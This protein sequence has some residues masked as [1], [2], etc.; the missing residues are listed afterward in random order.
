MLK[1][2][3]DA[4][5]ISVICPVYNARPDLL[6]AS[7][8]S[9]LAVASMHLHEL[10]LIDDASTDPSTI[11]A[12][13]ELAAT[14][15]RIMLIRQA[16]NGGP[17]IARNEGIRRASGDWIGFVDSDDLWLPGRIEALLSVLA[18]APGAGWIAGHH[19][20]LHHD[21]STCPAARLT[22]SCPFARLT[23]HI[24]RLQTPALTRAL[25]GNFWL[26]LGTSIIK[27]SLVRDSG[28]F[29]PQRLYYGEDCMFLAKLSVVAECYVIDADV[30]IYR[31]DLPSLM[32]SKR[33]LTHAYAAWLRHAWH[34]QRLLA[35]RREMR[36]ALYATYKGLA[37][38]NLLNARPLAAVGF[39]L[40]AF[41][42][43]PREIRDLFLFAQLAVFASSDETMRQ[44]YSGAA[45][46]MLSQ[47]EK[48]GPP[49][50]EPLVQRVPTDCELTD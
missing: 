6:T 49:D 47:N 46:F 5:R 10:I 40:R 50:V 22:D 3:Q 29:P 25:I 43:D 23:P 16:C 19:L 45:C 7:V 21:G 14:D 18:H 35:F 13:D 9:V 38:N 27:T 26:T 2:Q 36:W 8:K 41:A 39:A 15:P 28:G 33:R 44:R 32:S 11:A 4:L 30:C 24:V 48:P 34:E 20:N 17:G 12:C 1:D 31:R 42:L 37:L